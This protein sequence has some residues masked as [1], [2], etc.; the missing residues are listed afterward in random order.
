MQYE[1]AIVFPPV[2]VLMLVVVLEN[3]E[4]LTHTVE[5]TVDVVV[6][7]VML[8]EATEQQYPVEQSD[9][10]L[11][12]VTFPATVAVVVVVVASASARVNVI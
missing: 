4:A 9:V 2:V 6:P 8:V 1:Y 7:E 10:V 12:L 5:L 3:Y 11:Q